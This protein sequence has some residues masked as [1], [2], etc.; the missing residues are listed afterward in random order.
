MTCAACGACRRLGLQTKDPPPGPGLS[1][2]PTNLR[3]PRGSTTRREWVAAPG[4]RGGGGRPAG[5]PTC[6]R[7]GES[8]PAWL[9]A[10]PNSDRDEGVGTRRTR[11]SLVTTP[12]FVLG[13]HRGGSGVCRARPREVRELD[14]C[15]LAGGRGGRGG[16]VDRGRCGVHT[17]TPASATANPHPHDDHPATRPAAL[18]SAAQPRCRGVAATSFACPPHDARRLQFNAA[19]EAVWGRRLPWLN[20]W[21]DRSRPQSPPAPPCAL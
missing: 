14:D 4:G 2:S 16:G 8:G 3:G 20:R 21:L 15:R 19:D 17:D 18:Y 10:R 5:R 6:R 1:S 11:Q 7:A 12:E 9:L 13:G